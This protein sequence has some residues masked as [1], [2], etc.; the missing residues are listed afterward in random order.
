MLWG[1]VSVTNLTAP[2]ALLTARE[3]LKMSVLLNLDLIKGNAAHAA[4]VKSR[5][6]MAWHKN[7]MQ[8]W[9]MHPAVAKCSPAVIM[10]VHPA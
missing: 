3:K 9:R 7:K 10:Q 8:S 5:V 2:S 6:W 1:D 4:K